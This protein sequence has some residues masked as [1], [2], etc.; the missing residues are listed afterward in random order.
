MELWFSQPPICLQDFSF[1][2]GQ[3]VKFQVPK[4]EELGEM[5]TRSTK[6]KRKILSSR[7]TENW[8]ESHGRM[9]QSFVIIQLDSNTIEEEPQRK[10]GPALAE[11][12]KKAISSARQHPVDN[13]DTCELTLRPL[14]STVAVAEHL[15]STLGVFGSTVMNDENDGIIAWDYFQYSKKKMQPMQIIKV[16]IFQSRQAN[17]TQS[18]SGYVARIFSPVH[19]VVETKSVLSEE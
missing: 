9:N 4:E 12:L 5:S 13:R 6:K 15:K 19:V 10:M 17:L 11:K 18:F 16:A 7:K 1:V 3:A 8:G 14:G 2:H